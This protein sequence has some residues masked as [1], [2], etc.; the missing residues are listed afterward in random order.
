MKS[1][2]EWNDVIAKMSD[3]NVLWTYNISD[4]WCHWVSIYFLLF[5]FSF[6]II[7]SSCHIS[8]CGYILGKTHFFSIPR[9]FSWK[10][11]QNKT[12]HVFLIFHLSIRKT[13]RCKTTSGDHNILLHTLNRESDCK[14]GVEPTSPTPTPRRSQRQ[15]EFNGGGSLL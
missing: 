5:L 7:S 2:Y 12:K 13:F 4:H 15:I 9:M 6:L 1:L 11:G 14:I 10:L 3:E 8:W